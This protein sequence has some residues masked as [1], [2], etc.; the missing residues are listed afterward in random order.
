M[1]HPRSVTT[2]PTRRS[3]ATPCP[4]RPH[5]SRTR[6]PPHSSSLSSSL[7]ICLLVDAREKLSRSERASTL[8]DLVQAQGLHACVKPLPVGDFLWVAV[9]RGDRRGTAAGDSASSGAGDGASDGM[10]DGASG[11]GVEDLGECLVLDTVVERKVVGDFLSTIKNS[12]HYHSQKVRLQRCGLRRAFYLVE[13]PLERWQHV[14]E[15]ERMKAELGHI[16]MIDR[17]L[18]HRSPPI[19]GHIVT[20]FIVS[21][22]LFHVTSSHLLH[23]GRRLIPP[24]RLPSSC[25]RHRLF[26][27]GA[28]SPLA[29][30][31]RA[32]STRRSNSS[33]GRCSGSGVRWARA[34][35]SCGRK[36]RS[37]RGP[38]SAPP[39]RLRSRSTR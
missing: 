34:R 13:G 4:L 1:P 22:S 23:A 14:P 35:R 28:A 12:R 32:V 36:G 25:P 24:E 31:G 18:V 38:S 21:R 10:G 16:Q 5:V 37:I 11:R 27:K 17:L 30:A 7:Q 3:A 20:S 15:R 26:Q 39:P 19:H 9:P 33:K 8:C 6:T 29:R 2:R